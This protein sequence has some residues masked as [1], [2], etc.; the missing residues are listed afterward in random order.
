MVVVEQHKILYKFEI[1]FLKLIPM[2]ISSCQ[3]GNSILSYY[4]I[5]TSY[6]SYIAGIGLLPLLFLY[7]SSFV[8]RFCIYHRMFLYYILL[9]NVLCYIDDKY[10]IPITNRELLVLNIIIAAVFLFIIL[11]LKFKICKNK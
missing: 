6:L 1:L 7:L 4:C 8:F 2:I 10:G 3:L 9:N 11:Y 5:E